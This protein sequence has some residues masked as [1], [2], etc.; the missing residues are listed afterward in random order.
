MQEA[1][2]SQTDANSVSRTRSLRDLNSL[3]P[4]SEVVH[5]GV[6]A[7]QRWCCLICSSSRRLSTARQSVLSFAVE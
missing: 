1:R 5:H 6:P 3:T 4:S 7:S 2:F